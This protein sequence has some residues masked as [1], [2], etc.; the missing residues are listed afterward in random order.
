M[1]NQRIHQVILTILNFLRN[2]QSLNDVVEQTNVTESEALEAV[3]LIEK[4]LKENK[5]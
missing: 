2:G 5:I 1:A 3:D 4:A